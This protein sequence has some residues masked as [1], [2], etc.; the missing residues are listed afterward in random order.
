MQVKN[1]WD[2]KGFPNPQD[3]NEYRESLKFPHETGDEQGN[4]KIGDWGKT[5]ANGE[6]YIKL[7]W[8]YWDQFI[9]PRS[10]TFG[11]RVNL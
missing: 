10:V 5:D 11:L 7:G 9:N 2:W 6:D 1:L 3:Y 8:N 4:D